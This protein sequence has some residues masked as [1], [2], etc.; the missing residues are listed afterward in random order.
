MAAFI[1]SNSH[2]L[3]YSNYLFLFSIHSH[4]HSFSLYIEL[5]FRIS[6][7]EKKCIE[8]FLSLMICLKN[9]FYNAQ[10]VIGHIICK[11]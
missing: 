7:I 10:S 2:K 6:I 11:N 5:I 8:V 1:V 4:S 3:I 9:I